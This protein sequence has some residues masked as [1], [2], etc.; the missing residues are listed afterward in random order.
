MA[1]MREHEELTRKIS[2]TVK[3]RIDTE[4][5]SVKQIVESTCVT[6]RLTDNQK[7][8]IPLA[9]KWSLK[10]LYDNE[11]IIRTLLRKFMA[12][13]LLPIDKVPDAYQIFLIQ[14]CEK[15]PELQPFIS[16]FYN[17]WMILFK[18]LIWC[19]G[20]DEHRTNN[21]LQGYSHRLIRRT[22]ATHPNIWNFLMLLQR[23]D[24]IVSHLFAKLNSPSTCHAA[25]TDLNH[26]LIPSRFK[27]KYKTAQIKKLHQC[28]RD[29]T[30]SLPEV[31]RLLSFLVAGT[32]KAKKKCTKLAQRQLRVARR[33][34]QPQPDDNDIDNDDQ[35]A[36]TSRARCTRQKPQTRTRSQSRTKTNAT[37]KPKPCAVQRSQS[38]K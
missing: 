33:T 14:Q 7:Q 24:F 36:T 27:S 25:D 12:L 31:L 29:S 34:T 9:K 22:N 10:R 28:L 38:T 20:D 35:T 18:P 4:G 8:A 32:S 5:L 30:K 13:L 2:A 26:Q 23:E 1:F 11:P 16:Y 21:Q 19:V 37:S 6:L 17:E 3:E 15:F